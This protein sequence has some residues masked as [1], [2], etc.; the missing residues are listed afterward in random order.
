[1]KPQIALISRRDG[2]LGHRRMAVQSEGLALLTQSG[3]KIAKD[4]VAPQ[5]GR[6]DQQRHEAPGKYLARHINHPANA[7]YRRRG[8]ERRAYFVMD[9]RSAQRPQRRQSGAQNS[10]H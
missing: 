7:A 8:I 9:M 2:M 3:K 4:A 1:M 6:S 10:L 5:H